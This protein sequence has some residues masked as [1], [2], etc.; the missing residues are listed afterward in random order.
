[1][2]TFEPYIAGW[3]RGVGLLETVGGASMM[4]G[5]RGRVD[6]GAI[7]SDEESERLPIPATE[8]M[9]HVKRDRSVIRFGVFFQCEQSSCR[10]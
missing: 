4:G 10:L 2:S 6:W 7:E 9:F 5:W 8:H 3:K 1:M